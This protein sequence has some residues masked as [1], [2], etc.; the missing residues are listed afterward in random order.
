[1]EELSLQLISEKKGDLAAQLAY[2]HNS[3]FR[4]QIN[5]DATKI[6]D[7]TPTTTLKANNA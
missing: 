5:L 1:L 3:F 7:T 6:K 4:K 2:K